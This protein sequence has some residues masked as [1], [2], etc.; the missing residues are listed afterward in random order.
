MKLFLSLL[1]AALFVFTININAQEQDKSIRTR[2]KSLQKLDG[3]MPL[4][5]DAEAG[6]LL[7]EIERFNAEFLYQVS[8]PTGI[9]SNPIGLD[10]GQLG[11]T[12]VVFFERTGAK[13]LMVRP[14]Y[15]Y[16]AITA[17]PQ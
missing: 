11:T 10:R 14:N 5:W 8:L 6:K 15:R 17:D 7:M 9:G 2:T 1:L 4:Y 13:V 12:N 3:Y 16:R